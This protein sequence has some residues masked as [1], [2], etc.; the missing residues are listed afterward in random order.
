M[1]ASSYHS[2]VLIR[3]SVPSK[4]KRK[5]LSPIDGFCENYEFEEMQENMTARQVNEGI[6][7]PVVIKSRST[8][9]NTPMSNI[10]YEYETFITVV[11]SSPPLFHFLV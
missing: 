5:E 10:V 11:T 6:F 2:I 7:E 3:L 4:E 8:R 1:H 9:E